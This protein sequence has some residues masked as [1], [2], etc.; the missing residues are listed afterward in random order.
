MIFRALTTEGDWTFGAG[1]NNYASNNIAIGFNIETRIKSWLNDCFFD[2]NA[3]ID[4]VNRLGSKGQ[5]DLLEQDIRRIILQSYGVT[6]II[7]FD[8]ILTNRNLTTRY[9]ILTIFSTTFQN[10]VTIG[11]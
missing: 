4:W 7:S 10:T 9:N 5:R 11:F 8:T 6:S 3:G 2:Q 1:L